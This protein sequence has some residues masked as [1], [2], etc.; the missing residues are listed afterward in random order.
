MSLTLELARTLAVV[1]AEGT[2]EAAAR[3]LHLTP[4]AV[5]QR[6]RTLEEQVG[7]VLL[8]RSKPVRPTEAGAAIVRLGR[9][10][11]LLE[12]E[13]LAQLGDQPDGDPAPVRP[14]TVPLAVNADSLGTWFLTALARAAQ[15]QP[16]VFDL[17]RDDQAFTAGLLESGTVMAAVTSQAR[18]VSGC[19]VRPLGV[20]RYEPFATPAF[21]DRWFADGQ[22][23]RAFAVAPVVDFDRR[24]DLQSQFLRSR[25]ADPSLPP[26]NYVPSS[27]DY[28]AAVAL[29]LGWGLL[30]PQQSAPLLAERRIVRLDGEAIGVPLYWQQWNLRSPLLT[31]IAEEV[32]RAAH[33]ALA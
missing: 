3:A 25:G 28:A 15:R 26:R 19:V 13:A 10:L 30:P 14:T 17:H 8:V 18:P 1:A 7:R 24:D 4:S 2:I 20:M 5:S 29:G 32:A 6:I 23:A 33:E 9:Q 21:V 31:T 22:D 12:R 16:M 27:A 11:D